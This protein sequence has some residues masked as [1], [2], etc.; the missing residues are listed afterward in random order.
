MSRDPLLTQE[1]SG[2]EL[3]NAFITEV[4]TELEGIAEDAKTL[5]ELQERAGQIV[6]QDGE[7]LVRIEQNVDKADENV[8][9]AVDDIEVASGYACGGRKMIVIIVVVVLVILLA[10]GLGIAGGTG[11]FNRPPPSP[12]GS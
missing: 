11:A 2:A 10:I 3:E 8:K 4:N 5:K 12:P 7:K 6:Q 1:L 9:A